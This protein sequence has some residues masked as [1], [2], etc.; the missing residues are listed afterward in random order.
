VIRFLDNPCSVIIPRPQESFEQYPFCSPSLVGWTLARHPGNDGI[1]P[2]PP[3][4]QYISRVQYYLT[5]SG[6][7]VYPQLSITP[8]CDVVIAPRPVNDRVKVRRR[9][10]SAALCMLL[11][12]ASHHALWTN[13]GRLW[14]LHRTVQ[15][16]TQH[17][18]R[19]GKE[20][21]TLLCSRT[22]PITTS[23]T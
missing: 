2:G 20:C 15:T 1:D 12:L 3:F 4:S 23:Y 5:T 17:M 19:L 10:A 6:I 21:T 7:A 22:T 9:L 18:P 16:A 8:S 14:H 13:H 11:P